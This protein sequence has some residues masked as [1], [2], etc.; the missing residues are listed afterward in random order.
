MFIPMA[1]TVLFALLGAFFLT[2]T[3]IPVLAS[4][5][6]KGGHIAEEETPF[7]QKIHQ[8]YTPKLDYCLKESKKVT[9]STIGILILSIFLFFQLGGEFLP[10]LDEGNLLIEV[11]RYPSTTLT[12][13]LQSSMKIEKTILKEIPEITEIVSRSG[14]P[15]LAI[16]PMGVEKTDMYLDM[17]PRSEWNITKNEIELKLQEIIERV[18][19]QVA[20]GL[21]QPIEM[22][23]NE[24]M[25]GIRADVGIKVFGD[26]LIQL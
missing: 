8:W 24:I 12:E 4:Y 9:Y 18:A 25:A 5:F 13:S 10:K 21:S 14:S 15:E 23:N 6:L 7:F 16:E 17:K 20:Y 11:S 22:R 2:L 19:P 1:T 26:D 3:I